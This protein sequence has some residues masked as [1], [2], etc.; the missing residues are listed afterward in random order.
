[1]STIRANTL[2][3][4]DGSTTTEPSIP[5]LDQRMAKA[6][7]NYFS[8]GTVTIRSSYNVS[9]LT[10]IGIGTT[11]INFTTSLTNTTYVG[12]VSSSNTNTDV[13]NADY[14]TTR[15]VSSCN[16]NTNEGGTLRDSSD[17]NAIV[18]GN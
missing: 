4:S 7:V 6:W 8:A 18:F 16:V 15:T 9:S 17:V 10:D 11:T 2:L 3:H 12:V 5:A 1:M 13:G 14:M